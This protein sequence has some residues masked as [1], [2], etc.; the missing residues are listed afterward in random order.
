MKH[1]MLYRTLL[2]ICGAA[3]FSFISDPAA[4]QPAAASHPAG[5]C[6]AGITGFTAGQAGIYV[7]YPVPWPA[8][9]KYSVVVQQGNTAGYSP[10]TVCTYFNVLKLTDLKFE[11]QHK[12]CDD[13]VPV[14][15]DT[16]AT[17]FWIAC[18]VQ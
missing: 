5:L 2:A 8:G 14:A 11:I 13:G 9:T 7:N 1:T 3:F 10:T 12:R 18:P 4:A 17:I 15:L 16:N 6:K